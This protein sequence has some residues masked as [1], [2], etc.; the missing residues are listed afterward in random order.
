MITMQFKELI[1]WC[2]VKANECASTAI[3]TVTLTYSTIIC[4]A[5]LTNYINMV[6]HEYCYHCQCQLL[7][8]NKQWQPVMK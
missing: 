2:M 7:R 4:H 5:I 8:I 1:Y 3:T 6:I